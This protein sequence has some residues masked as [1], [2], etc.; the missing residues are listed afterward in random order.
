MSDDFYHDDPI[1][2]E[3][4]RKL[5]RKFLTT[6]T[7]LFASVLFFQSTFA[8]NISLNSGAGIEFGQAVSQTVAC[9]GETSLT[10][11]P[12]SSFVNG[13]NAGG[14]HYLNS[15]K[16]SNIPTSCYGADFSINAYGNSDSA[17]LAVINTT[18][19]GVGVYNNMELRPRWRMFSR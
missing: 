17:A 11:T 19:S 12:Y 10:V 4:K 7:V 5:Q 18:L 2:V 13:A 1:E 8:G 9:S 6:A 16:V 15:I 14:S 3:P